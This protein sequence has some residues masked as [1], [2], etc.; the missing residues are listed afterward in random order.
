MKDV[1]IY[2]D[3]FNSNYY[4]WIK[5][6]TNSN[7]CYGLGSTPDMA[8]RCLKI[9]INQ[10]KLRQTNYE[11]TTA[12]QPYRSKYSNKSITRHDKMV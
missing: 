1:L 10:L 7:I 2:K 9:R 3:V 6:D 5:S 12:N 8:I 11:T 4:A